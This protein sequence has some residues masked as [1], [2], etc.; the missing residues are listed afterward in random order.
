M[1]KIQIEYTANI[2]NLKSKL[3]DLIAINEKLSNSVFSTKA[4][5]ENMSKTA[6]N[7]PPP[8]FNNKNWDKETSN[9]KKW[10]KETEDIIKQLFSNVLEYEK[11]ADNRR[12]KFANDDVNRRRKVAQET[13]KYDQETKKLWLAHLAEMDKAAAESQKRRLKLGEERVKAKQREVEAK[14]KADAE[15]VRWWEKELGRLEKEE[16]KRAQQSVRTTEKA[17]REK[18]NAESR[19]SKQR[20]A[21]QKRATREAEKEE[22]KRAAAA[23][24]AEREKVKATQKAESERTAAVQKSTQLMTAPLRELRNLVAGAFAIGAIKAFT[25]E[26]VVLLAEL[27]ILQS[28]INFIYGSETGGKA[29]FL[30]LS[31]AIKDLGLDFKTTIEQF[32]TFNI[33][34]QQA[35]FTTVESEKMFID[36]AASLRAVGASNLQVQRA[37]YALQ[38]MMSKGVVAAEE[39]RRQMGEALPGAGALMFKAFK[40]LHPEMVQTERDFMKLQE[41][42][43]VLSREVLPEFVKVVKEEFSPALEAKKDSLTAAIERAEMSW[44]QFKAALLDTEP[45]KRSLEFVTQQLDRANR[46]F[47]FYD[48]EREK[49][50]QREKEEMGKQRVGEG[51]TTPF[52]LTE[53]LTKPLLDKESMN[54]LQLFVEYGGKGAA[55]YE[56]IALSFAKIVSYIKGLPFNPRAGGGNIFAMETR[57]V[58]MEK[59]LQP[60]NILRIAKER[61]EINIEQELRRLSQVSKLRPGEE[62]IATEQQRKK[63]REEHANDY[64]KIYKE[65]AKG[66]TELL[67]WLHNTE[68]INAATKFQTRLTEDLGKFEK[69][70]NEQRAAEMNRVTSQIRGMKFGVFQ[71]KTFERKLPAEEQRELD[72]LLSL[73]KDYILKDNA[74]R[75]EAAD[76][77]DEM[78]KEEAD[79]RKK[80]LQGMVDLAKIAVQEEKH[81][82]RVKGKDELGIEQTNSDN[83]L[84]LEKN[85]AKAELNLQQFNDKDAAE[86]RIANERE[87]Q[88]TLK[89][90]D[91]DFAEYNK[92]KKKEQTKAEIDE[93]IASLDRQL[94][95]T[96]EY[97]K[98]FLKLTSDRLNEERQLNELSYKNK[99]INAEEYAKTA[100][101]IDKKERDTKK[102]HYVALAQIDIAYIE[103]KIALVQQEFVDS[104][105]MSK[106][107]LSLNEELML[108]QMELDIKQNELHGELAESRRQKTLSEIKKMYSD[109]RKEDEQYFRDLQDYIDEPFIGKVAMERRGIRQETQDQLRRFDEQVASGRL[110]PEY[111]T[112]A[113]MLSPES[114]NM[115]AVEET[116]RKIRASGKKREQG[117]GMQN[118]F[119][120][121][122]QGLDN[123]NFALDTALS[124][125]RSFYDL[126]AEMAKR[127]SDY[128]A[129]LLKKRLDAGLIRENEYNEELKKIQEKQAR[130]ERDA[131]IFKIT[132]DTAQAVMNVWAN[133]KGNPILGGV[134]TALVVGLGA[135]QMSAVNSAPLP[136][137]HEGGLDIKSG[138]KKRPDNGLKQGEFYAKLLEGESV[139]TREE[140]A[141]YKDVLKAIRE[142]SLPLQEESAMTRE[143]T[144][145]YNNIL[146]AIYNDS[147]PLQEES[148]MTREQTIKYN[149]ILKAIHE[150]L[151]PLQEESVM[152]REQTI[153]YKNILKAIHEDLPPLQGGSAMTREQTIKYKN[154]LK[155]IYEYSLPLQ[156]ES[157]LTRGETNKYKDVLKTIRED[158]PPL[159]IESVL[160]GGETNKY[161][162]V[163][164]TIREDSLPSQ[165]MKGYTAP[166]YHRSMDEPYRMAKEQTS[167][168][169]A[170]Q[171]AELVDAIKRNG[172]VAIKNADELAD[173]IVSKSSYT[174]I[175]NRR[176]IR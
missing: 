127:A 85:L 82:L 48:S 66:N 91:L 27:E 155:A 5:L 168:E 3:N 60:E 58:G 128:E 81:A 45:I 129:D 93:N 55:Y 1:A 144:I 123:L 7:I 33:A 25:Q 21:E 118:I 57:D 20:E 134:L 18:A 50:I 172:A 84:K 165:I 34:A 78:S 51:T 176:R 166:A 42:G 56:A 174:K 94:I 87:Y 73:S 97:E 29:G 88:L 77:N 153:K 70:N 111:F 104:E 68:E 100:A 19:S 132:L 164:K 173:A 161:K 152:T 170:F 140:T 40:N 105:V 158:S 89:K 30:R 41:Q 26:L 65:L 47:A 175:T 116:R 130:V 9:S 75:Q 117:L 62:I 119:G 67:A 126:R 103:K 16:A 54:A 159:Q 121:S 49:A 146:K 46:A 86:K 32:T 156:S 79:K 141:K 17:A 83:L 106:R 163:L 113:T 53:A 15:Y 149:N 99:E 139:M 38:Q 4:A 131:A 92:D 122:D 52:N 162:D 71:G 10:A 61:N 44:M 151:P 110:G 39:L 35:N 14:K 133:V 108:A 145:K 136:T 125:F 171:N 36:F 28:R 98:E 112:E 120:L 101:Q 90:L 114:I 137:F 2:E 138:D 102:S 8:K 142:D 160:T 80:H 143:Q 13:E 23:E 24:K 96:K 74:I 148:A 6:A 157:V 11:N 169:L 43:K 95:D 31:S 59:Y 150:D 147:L 109:A 63:F 69:L 37:F 12:Q 22:R 115:E 167:L 76:K 72:Y 154:I 64:I 135:A 107:E 124:S